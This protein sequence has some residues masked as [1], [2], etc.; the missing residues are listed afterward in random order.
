MARSSPPPSRARIDTKIPAYHAVS[1]SRRRASDCISAA[2]G[3]EPVPGAAQRRDQLR[4][5][6][7]IDLAPQA[8]DEHL[9]HVGERVVVVVDRKS[10]RLNSSHSLTSRM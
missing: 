4:L 8:R 10:T 2:S 6:A 9:E 3:A 7:V 5:E 1:R